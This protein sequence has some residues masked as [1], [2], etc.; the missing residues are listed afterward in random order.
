MQVSISTLKKSLKSAWGVGARENS[1]VVAAKIFLC[2]IAE[3]LHWREFRDSQ[4]APIPDP[5]L[6]LVDRIVQIS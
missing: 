5:F 4:A 1:D 3:M 2:K 6:D